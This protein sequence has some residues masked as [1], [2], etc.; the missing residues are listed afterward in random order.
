MTTSDLIAELLDQLGD[1]RIRR[2]QLLWMPDS[3]SLEALG[4]FQTPSGN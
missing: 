2:I 3:D 1:D 4:E